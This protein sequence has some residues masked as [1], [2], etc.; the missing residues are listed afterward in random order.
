MEFVFENRTSTIGRNRGV[1]WSAL[2]FFVSVAGLVGLLTLTIT[3]ARLAER[4]NAQTAFASDEIEALEHLHSVANGAFLHELGMTRFASSSWPVWRVGEAS[5]H[6]A[7]LKDLLG[8][9]PS[10][11]S[12]L[13][14]LQRSTAK[15]QAQLDEAT[16]DTTRQGERLSIDSIKLLAANETLQFI[17]GGLAKLRSALEDKEEARAS[18]TAHTLAIERIMLAVCAIAA[19]A[20]LSYAL[21]ANQRAALARAKA[22][23][24]AHEAE[25]RFREYFE[26]HP[27]AMIIYDV[28]TLEILAANA[29]AARQYGYAQD[30]FEKLPITA[31][32]PPEQVAQFRADLEKFNRSGGRSGSAGMRNHLGREGAVIP[33]DVSY[34]FL[35]YGRRSACFIVA[36]DVSTREQAQDELRSAKQMLDMVINTVPHRIFWKKAGAQY[37]GCNRAFALDAALADPA[38]VVGLSDEDMPWSNFV[39]GVTQHDLAVLASGTP[40]LNFEVFQPLNPEKPRW[41]RHNRLPLYDAHG[42][43]SAILGTYEDITQ[44]K[45]A[46]LALRLRSRALDAIVNAVLITRTEKGVEL[47]Q[48]A[49]PA[50]E[51]ITGYQRHEVEGK[52]FGFLQGADTAQSCIDDVR[53]A[54]KE[55]REITTMLKSSRKDGTVFWNQLYVAPVR[56]EH[57]L[58][59]HHISVINDVTELVQSRDMLQK[60]AR[61]DALTEL[62]NRSLLNERLEEEICRAKEKR[63]EVHLFFIDVDHFKDVNDSMGHAAGDRLLREIASRLSDCVGELGTVARY[64]GDEFVLVVPSV[65]SQDCLPEIQER[66]SC[67]L[68]LPVAL[69]DTE[70]HVEVSVGVAIFPT[71]ATDAR[72][73][74][75]NADLAL[76]E[77]KSTGRNRVVIFNRALAHIAD[78]RIE[79]SRRLRHA[80]KNHEFALVYQPQVDIR[81]GHITGVEALIRWCDSELGEISPGTF[82]PAAE[83]NGLII[84]IG[85]WVLH[86]ACK[87]AKAW[88]RVL[89][90]LRMSV[91]VSPKQFGGGDLFALVQRALSIASL[92]SS[93]LELEITEGALME[94]GALEVLSNLR[95]AGVTIAIDDFGTGYSSLAYV[96][97]F[98][99][100]RLKLDMSFVRGIGKSCEDE[101]I[102]R[103]ILSL[104]NTLGFEVVAEGV[105]SKAQLA[106]LEKYG[107]KVV[108]GYLFARPMAADDA[109]SFMVAY[110][111]GS[112]SC[113][114]TFD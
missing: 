96:R 106:F 39:D 64:G 46:E 67:Q 111:A 74:L 87:Q 66:L 33:V 81:T 49:N 102:V 37:L 12:D 3:T 100:D 98:R 11:L 6:Y 104:G 69:D 114:N 43:I 70:L 26:A 25:A 24:V 92:P 47:I 30:V 108:Q 83:E 29:A 42:T 82:I 65:S 32:H 73:L 15:W 34:H 35:Q 17:S 18:E 51:R 89:P 50:F 7:Q 79:L 53:R 72:S 8:S 21:L 23:I 14:D 80:L 52:D 9:S 1:R 13:A 103:A 110:K 60:Q 101:A 112:F 20:F 27:L 91:N 61:F 57:N 44:S 68:S 78:A 75:I 77:A 88:E 48:Y 5:R 4:E 55:E 10:A 56:D 97:N 95:S 59:T 2:I 28:S 93:S 40:Q 84:S 63:G 38:D 94:Y 31:L 105:E 22:K 76:Y 107:C 85:E 62:P 36:I 86:E 54:L 90:G 41:L 19:L 109:E 16:T 45:N 113:H 58:V 71:D 99:A